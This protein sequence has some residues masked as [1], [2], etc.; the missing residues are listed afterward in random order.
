MMPTHLA[1][2]RGINV[3]GKNL[4][5]MADL[6]AL[7][8]SLQFQNVKTLLQSG[9]IVFEGG[10]KTGAALEKFLEAESSKK[11]GR[12]VDYH[13]RTAAEWNSV[14]ER[15]PFPAEAKNDPARLHV[16]LFKDAPAAKNVVALEA[17]IK[18]PEYLQFD[19]CNGYFVYPAGVGTSKLT[20]AVIDRIL[21]L[22]GTA[23][24]WNTALK[25]AELVGDK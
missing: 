2:L 25:L 7:L 22:R 23:R 9:N 17:A 8:E 1:F 20:P 16:I 21:G 13:V 18:G 3:G 15:N 4:I 12:D 11:F 5:A 24:N 6:R 19:G 14:I 10:R